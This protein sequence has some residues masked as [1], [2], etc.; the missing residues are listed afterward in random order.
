MIHLSR[1]M[2]L[3]YGQY[4][5]RVNAMCPARIVTEAKK[6]MLD[7]SP[8]AVRNQKHTY[9]LGR[10]GTMRE[11]AM[12]ALFLVSDEASFVTGAVLSV[13]GGMIAQAADG[14]A[15]YLVKGV[16]T[17]LGLDEA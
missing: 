8:A 12:A 17:E 2:V 14:A 9:P 5:V 10:P 4:G 13:D 16:L 1:Q 3:D 6:E 11:A 7:A 15:L